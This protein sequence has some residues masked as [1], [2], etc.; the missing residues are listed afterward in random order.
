MKI[1]AIKTYSYNTR[2]NQA[3]AKPQVQAT[4]SFNGYTFNPERT[5]ALADI[6]PI[7]F[8]FDKVFRKSMDFSKLRQ[9]PIA[10]D[11]QGKVQEITIPINRSNIVAWDINDGSRNKYVLFLHGTGQNITHFQEMYRNILA[12]T[13]F[14]ILAP[15]FRGFGKNIP[16]K[17]S[18]KTIFQDADA[19]YKFLRAPKGIKREDICLIGHSLGCYPATQIASQ[20]KGIKELV[21]LSP[22][23]SF[24]EDIDI[25]QS[26]GKN[27][28]ESVIQLFDKAGFLSKQFEDL[29][30]VGKIIKKTQTPVS[31]VHSKKDT[32]VNPNSPIKLA[33]QCKNLKS[34]NLL[35][36]GSHLVDSHKIAV[37][38]QILN[39]AG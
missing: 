4:P 5:L 23:H 35:D 39:N 37:L 15:E 2:A 3:Y 29:Y 17:I 9:R 13:D 31:I 21:L 7:R 24:K 1:H 26:L 10:K 8:Y 36:A 32:L 12:N 18:G 30:A 11:L 20:H 33:S 27:V 16:E 6:N 25:R 38:S 19:A 22:I 14:A 28:P 34:L